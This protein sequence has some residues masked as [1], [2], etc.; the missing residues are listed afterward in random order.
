MIASPRAFC[1]LIS[2]A[3]PHASWSLSLIIPCSHRRSSYSSSRVSHQK[4]SHPPKSIQ[5]SLQLSNDINEDDDEIDQLANDIGIEI[6]RGGGGEISEET[7]RDIQ[8]GAPSKFEAM[9]SVSCC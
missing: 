1:I 4:N 6:V 9:K 3:L 2:L 5:T 7:W 8:E